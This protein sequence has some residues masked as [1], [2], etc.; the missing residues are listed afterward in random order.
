MKSQNTLCK[1]KVECLDMLIHDLI[2]PHT[3]SKH[4]KKTSGH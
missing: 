4:N 1:N 3:T 2:Q